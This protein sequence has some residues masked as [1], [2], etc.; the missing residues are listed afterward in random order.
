MKSTS[1]YFIFLLIAI[2]SCSKIDSSVEKPDKL[3]TQQLQDTSKIATS[4]NS[5]IKRLPGMGSGNGSH[6]P[7][8][9]IAADVLYSPSKNEYY[10]NFAGGISFGNSFPYPTNVTN[11]QSGLL[12]TPTSVAGGYNGNNLLSWHQNGPYI[13]AKVG[14][15]F[16][17]PN[18]HE[19]LKK[20]YKRLDDYF[21]NI[22]DSATQ[23]LKEFSL[24]YPPTV[25]SD[26]EITYTGTFLLNVD[27]RETHV[28]IA[29]GIQKSTGME[30]IE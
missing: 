28:S 11:S 7:G 4:E 3:T 30:E 27:N 2:A 23:E 8:T 25:T 24:P 14:T 22:I 16:I 5:G 20:Y 17:T 6:Q 10:S 29:D 13:T 15:G 12:Y 9:L 21:N 26:Y 1:Y 19:M 18:G